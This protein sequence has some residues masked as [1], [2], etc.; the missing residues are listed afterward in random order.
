MLIPIQ[1]NPFTTFCLYVGARVFVQYLKS[2]P[3]DFQVKSSLHFLL[4]VMNVF[5]RRNPLVESFLVQLDVDLQAAGLEEFRSLRTRLAKMNVSRPTGSSKAATSQDRPAR[6]TPQ[7]AA[8]GETVEPLYKR[9]PTFGD[10]GLTGHAFPDLTPTTSNRPLPHDTSCR[11]P[12]NWNIGTGVLAMPTRSKTPNLNPSPGSEGLMDIMSDVRE[13]SSNESGQTYSNHGSTV[14][15]TPPS[16]SQDNSEQMTWDTNLSTDRRAVYLGDSQPLQGDSFDRSMFEYGD[17]NFDQIMDNHGAN[18]DTN[19][20]VGTTRF[21]FTMQS[22]GLTPGNFVGGTGLTPDATGE[23]LNMSDEE[24]KRLMEGGAGC[25]AGEMAW[26]PN[27]TDD[28]GFTFAPS[29]F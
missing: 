4:T 29:T 26:N 20:G 11:V 6:D 22:T 12:S 21:E 14:S 2:R 16:L 3:N 15:F 28:Q 23:L 8:F 19:L 5:K 18:I 9:A 1:A 13:L 24:W 7:T 27:L 10:G 17:V 25:G